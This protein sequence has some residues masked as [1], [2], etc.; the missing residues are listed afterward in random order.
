MAT[1]TTEFSSSIAS[2]AQT[3]VITDFIME[4]V[5]IDS[6]FDGLFT[7]NSDYI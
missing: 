4:P 2:P 7:P 6:Y 5:F 1:D 3:D